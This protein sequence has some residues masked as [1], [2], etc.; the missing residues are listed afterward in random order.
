MPT[1]AVTPRFRQDLKSLTPQQR[2][3][4]ENVVRNDFVPDIESG[5]FRASLR[6][7]RVQSTAVVFEMSWAPDGRATWQYG[8][9]IRPGVR[10][11]IWR[12]IGTHSIFS[13]GPP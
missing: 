13:P 9:Q 4:F 6:V 1:F 5:Q 7:K 3:R 10:H 11:V 12:R 2:R 8:S